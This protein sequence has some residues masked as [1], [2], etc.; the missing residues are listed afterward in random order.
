[1]EY[2][3]TFID[4]YSSYR[5]IYLNKNKF[6]AIDKL[7]EFKLE[8]EKH[9]GRSIK[10]LNN[11]RGGEYEAMDNLCKE[12]GIKHLYTMPYKP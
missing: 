1:M 9:I 6:E 2:F 4:D 8:V 5:Y 12:N 11:D 7:K 3:I 10:T